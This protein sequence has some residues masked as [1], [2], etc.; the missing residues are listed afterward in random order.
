[1]IDD[2]INDENEEN[3]LQMF[4]REPVK[5]SDVELEVIGNILS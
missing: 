1:M 3:I 2:D 5:R 4:A